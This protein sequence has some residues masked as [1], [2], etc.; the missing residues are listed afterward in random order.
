M[1]YDGRMMPQSDPASR[2]RTDRATEADL[3]AARLQ[4]LANPTRLKVM[5][6]LWRLAGEDAEITVGRLQEV[7]GASQSALSQHLARLR[8]AGL[9]TTRRDGQN[10]LYRL[11]DGEA[12]RMMG[13]ICDGMCDRLD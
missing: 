1:H 7:T 4:E 10:I 8:A 2:T 3:L 9:V 13:A 12:R 6:R 11:A 5:C